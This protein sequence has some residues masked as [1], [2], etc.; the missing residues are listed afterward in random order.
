MYFVTWIDAEGQSF[1]T[2]HFPYSLKKFPFKEGGFY[3]KIN[4]YLHE[5]SY[6]F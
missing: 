6:L 1:D 5:I 2:V 4:Q 3:Y